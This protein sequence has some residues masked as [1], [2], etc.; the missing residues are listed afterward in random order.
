MP[1]MYADINDEQYVDSYVCIYTEHTLYN[2]IPIQIRYLQ[3]VF[4]DYESAY[5]M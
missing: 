5:F 3:S 1:T 4:A 2:Y